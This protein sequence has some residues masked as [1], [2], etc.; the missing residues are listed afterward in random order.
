MKDNPHEGA[1]GAATELQ[2]GNVRVASS[3]IESIARHEIEQVDGVVGLADSE[4]GSLL[5]RMGRKKSSGKGVTVRFDDLDHIYIDVSV[6]VE[7]GA[8]IPTVAQQVQ[9]AVLTG[10]HR[11]THANISQININVSGIHFP[12]GQPPRKDD[13]DNGG[14][15]TE[16]KVTE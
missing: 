4:G 8:F 9:E 10:I 14:G 6:I 5:D 12:K 3:V 2:L 11:M 1:P 7:Y 13:S 15:P 16:G